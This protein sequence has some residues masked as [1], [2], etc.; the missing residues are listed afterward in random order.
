[1]DKTERKIFAIQVVIV[2]TTSV[3]MLN[4]SAEKIDTNRENS[5]IVH[6]VDE[7]SKNIPFALVSV[8]WPYGCSQKFTNSQ[9]NAE[10]SIIPPAKIHV[11][12]RKGLICTSE[13]I[14]LDKENAPL[15]VNIT[16]PSLKIS[17]L[18]YF[19]FII[20]FKHFHSV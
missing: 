3:F 14:D 1:M 11:S 20:F 16:L 6:V 13:T 10:F 19:L 4:V 2:L 8:D 18:S 12:V 15:I 9:G 17:T 5:L 7:D